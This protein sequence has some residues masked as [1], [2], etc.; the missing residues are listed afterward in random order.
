MLRE[1]LYRKSFLAVIICCC[2]VVSLGIM[3]SATAQNIIDNSEK[4]IDYTHYKTTVNG[5]QLHYVIGGDGQRDPIVLLHGR[6][7]T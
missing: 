2:S 5:I 3:S 1:Y 7:Q 6:P 4:K